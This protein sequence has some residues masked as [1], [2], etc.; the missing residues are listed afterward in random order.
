MAEQGFSVNDFGHLDEAQ[1]VKYGIY[2]IYDTQDDCWLGDD[3]GPRLYDRV[4][5][6]K[7]NG[8]PQQLAARIAA[9]MTAVQ[10]GYPQTRLIARVYDG[11]GTK[12]RDSV[13]TKMTAVE[14]LRKLENGERD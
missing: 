5:S 10:L 11:S 6:E 8:M 9:Q 1:D 14:A 4:I 12:L 3:N 7:L 2:G 13:D